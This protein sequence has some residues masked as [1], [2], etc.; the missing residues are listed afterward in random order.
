MD[1]T[2]LHVDQ[3]CFYASVEMLHH[4]EL[5][6]KP[7]A[8]GGDPQARHGI[9]LTANYAAKKYGVKTGMVLWQAGQV[10]PGL[11]VLPPRMDLYMRFS[12]LAKE[13]Y[14]EYTD[15]Q[16][17]FGLDEAWLDCTESME[18]K[19]SGMEIAQEISRRIKYELGLT[20]SIGVSWNKIFA[21]L[22]SDYKKPDAITQITRENYKRLVWSLP[23]KDLLYVGNATAEKLCKYGIHTI[24]DI[25]RAE[26]GFLEK[27]LGKMGLILYSFAN[28][29][30]DSPVTMENYLKSIGNSTTTPRDLIN[31][32]DVKIIII[33]LSESVAA[34]L[35]ENGFKCRTVELLV[36][37]NELHS[38]TWQ[39]KL[40]NPGNITNDI[41]MT[42]ME[43][44]RMHY[45][46]EK[47]VRSLGVRGTDLILDTMP[48]QLNLFLSVQQLEKQKKL[49]AA[50]DEIRRRFGYQSVQRAF[51]YRDRQLSRLDAGKD[52]TVHPVGFFHDGTGLEM[53]KS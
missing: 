22:G 36:R 12:K 26:M 10:C 43:L 21:K 42:A 28:G 3:N 23:A 9:V 29:W 14:S 11:V 6:G 46:L 19:G 45:N 13:I 16:Q 27:N 49:D 24:G 51:V 52:H 15:R 37:D 40:K 8:V 4:P 17:S 32:T 30:D 34:R 33:A 50:V 18:I 44:F 35:R 25:A 20:V 39:K 1:R 47:P 53:R 2:I 48:E 31:E 38:F 41:W 5:E 7:L